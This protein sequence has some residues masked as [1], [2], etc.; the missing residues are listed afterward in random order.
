MDVVQFGTLFSVTKFAMMGVL[1]MR[2][3]KYNFTQ[4]ALMNFIGIGIWCLAFGLFLSPIS[5][6]LDSFLTAV[7]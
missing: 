6:V 3:K 5:S 4:N 7:A 2:M 1:S